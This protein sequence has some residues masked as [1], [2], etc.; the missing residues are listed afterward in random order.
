[1]RKWLPLALLICLLVPLFGAATLQTVIGGISQAQVPAVAVELTQAQAQADF[2]LMRK[3]LEEAHTGLYRYLTKAE[4]DRVF[5]A[6]RAKLN[7]AMTKV[8]FQAVLAETLA[9]IRCGHTGLTPDNETQTAVTNARKFPLRMLVEG[10]R[11]MVVF[12]DTPADRTIQPGMEIVEINGRKTGDILN[13]IWPALPADGDIE[14]GKRAR[15]GGRF[16][17]HYWLLVEQ[18]SEFTVKAKDTSGKTVTAKLA[19]VTDAERT[20]NQNPVNAA[21]KASQDKFN[22]S[23]E[24]LGLRFL[25][26]PEIAQIRIRGFG[27]NDYPKWMEE[28]FKTLREK[29]TKTLILDLRGNGGGSDMYGAMLV[30]YLTDMPFRYFDHINVKTITPSFKEYSDWRSEREGQLRAD[31]TVNPAGGYLVPPKIHPGVAEQPPGKYPFMGKVFVL[32]DGGTFSTAADFCAVTHHLKRA[33]FIGEETGGGYYG[34]N[35]GMQTIVMLPNSKARIRLP[36]YEYWNAVPGYDGKRRG[37]RPDHT[38]ETKAANLLRGVDE[39]LELAL[40][41]S[42]QT[43]SK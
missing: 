30:S 42:A 12:N 11:L 26:E 29:G 25:K 21:M 41:L 13:R 6:Q 27:G 7:R 20:K 10:R 4:M 1:M 38:V 18:T 37:T 36:M 23:S 17:L 31:M 28:T 22:W 33:T 5:A 3:A 16:G 43:A 15:I 34:N 19:G 2:D 35:S 40:K 24:N 32:I 8:E 9:Y 14:T 39:Q